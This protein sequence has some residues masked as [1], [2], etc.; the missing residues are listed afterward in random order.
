M[1][2][3]TTTPSTPNETNLMV[4]PFLLNTFL[5]INYSTINLIIFYTHAPL[6]QCVPKIIIM[7]LL[8]IM[9]N[10]DMHITPRLGLG[11]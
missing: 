11:F 6:K 9:D 1:F 4:M 5:V 8:L 2:L 3:E 10:M 7:Y